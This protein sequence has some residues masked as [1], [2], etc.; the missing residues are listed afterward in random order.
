MSTV[1]LGLAPDAPV[2]DGI[3]SADLVVLRHLDGTHSRA[4]L[5]ALAGHHGLSADRVDELIALLE[6]H[7][8]LLGRRSAAARD[9]A[10]RP[11]PSRRRRPQPHGRSDRTSLG[12]GGGV[13]RDRRTRHR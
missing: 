3:S 7:G 10:P 8:V 12:T 9:L 11:R 2:L 1:Q 13:R 6:A 4:A 5:V